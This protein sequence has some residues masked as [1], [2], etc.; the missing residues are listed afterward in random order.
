MLLKLFVIFIANC[1]FIL[2]ILLDTKFSTE[3]LFI[4]WSFLYNNK[5]FAQCSAIQILVSWILRKDL[6]DSHADE[7]VRVL[8]SYVQ[9]YPGGLA[10]HRI[11]LQSLSCNLNLY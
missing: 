3:S 6:F 9:T 7:A 8:P 5:E 4:I 11:S 2:T 10:E 1:R